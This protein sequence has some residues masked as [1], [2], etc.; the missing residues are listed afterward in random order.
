MK[1]LFFPIL[2]GCRQPSPL[3]ETASHQ[4][5]LRP[6]SCEAVPTLAIGEPIF[7]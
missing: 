5:V 6:V 2:Q 7:T 1:N 3:T 4:P